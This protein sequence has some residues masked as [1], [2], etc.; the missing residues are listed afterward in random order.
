MEDSQPTLAN[1][2]LS[3]FNREAFSN[4]RE[5]MPTASIN[6]KKGSAA[7]DSE[8]KNKKLTVKLKENEETGLDGFLNQTTA[9]ALQ[10]SHRGKIVYKWHSPY[11]SSSSPHIIFSVSKSLTAL[12]I[13]CII[14]EGLVT[15]ETLVSQIIPEAKGSAFENASVRNLLDMSV[16]SNFIED[17][18]AT[19]GIFL[20]YRQSTGW[21]PQNID[22]TSHLKSFLL[23]LKKNTHGHGEKFEYHSTNT[24]M[25]GIIIEKCTG[26]KYAHYFYE[27]LMKPLGAKDDAYVTLDRMGTSRAAGGICISASDI[28]SICEM[29]R[30]FGKNDQG[31]QVFPENWIKDILN[32]ETDKRFNLDGHY[33]IFPEGLYR[34]KWYRPYTSQ[35][36]IFGLGIHGQWIWID[37]DKELSIVCLSSEPNPII[38]NNIK[39][40]SDVFNQITKQLV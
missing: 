14:D 15:E 16:S 24:D 17:Y 26:K 28:M 9:D 8:S 11:C 31:A 23:S 5:I 29:V 6:W 35:N 22:D 33:D 7:Q 19:S 27:K 36:I 20:D 21:N 40:M 2:R 30:T 13:G 38:S 12:L 32:S 37:F 39:Q 10:V 1:W 18:E 3:P 25:L 4:V 34:S